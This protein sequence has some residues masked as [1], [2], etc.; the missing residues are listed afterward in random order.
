M[1]NVL[2]HILVYEST[3]PLLRDGTDDLATRVAEL[4]AQDKLIEHQK[5]VTVNVTILGKIF[6]LVHNAR[7]GYLGQFRNK[8]TYP[9]LYVSITGEPA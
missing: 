7:Y 2:L 3:E 1:T 5:D 4:T 8:L 6:E 9:Y